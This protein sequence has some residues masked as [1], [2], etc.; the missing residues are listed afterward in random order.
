MG[1]LIN[2]V[3]A[4][5]RV[6]NLWLEGKIEV[7]V[8]PEVREEYL[9]TFSRMGFGTAE[10]VRRRERA[11]EKLLRQE[12]V[13]LVEPGF[14]L[15]VITEDQSDNRLLECAVSGRADYIISQDR[16]LLRVG[17]YD[18]I[19]IL[20]ASAFIKRERWERI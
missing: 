7:L 10:A 13:I 5:G 3:K 19:T 15:Q 16:H 8:S 6:V 18:G 17:R 4:S 14:R 11:L 1:G 2:P 20:S 9:H 12:N